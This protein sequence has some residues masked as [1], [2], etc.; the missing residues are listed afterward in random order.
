MYDDDDDKDDDNRDMYYAD[1]DDDI[2]HAVYLCKDWSSSR[3]GLIMAFRQCSGSP[4][5]TSRS[6]SLQVALLYLFQL[7]LNWN[8]P[9]VRYVQ[10]HVHRSVSVCNICCILCIV[11]FL[12][13]SDV[14]GHL[15]LG[16]WAYILLRCSSLCEMMEHI[17][18]SSHLLNKLSH[19]DFTQLLSVV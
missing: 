13:I 14:D 10:T 12:I 8:S 15:W 5:S 6:R 16:T 1:I 17:V 4:A 11:M 19:D 18:E 2:D 3:T 9:C 7:Q